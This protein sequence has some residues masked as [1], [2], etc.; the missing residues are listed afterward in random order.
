VKKL[1]ETID[2]LVDKAKGENIIVEKKSTISETNKNKQI[3]ESE[4]NLRKYIRTRLEE[5]AG[6]KKPII[7]ENKKSEKLKKLDVLIE[8]QY[9]LFKSKIK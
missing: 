7:T 2:G 3:S 8:N 5:N 4:Q 9:K 1:R 6:L